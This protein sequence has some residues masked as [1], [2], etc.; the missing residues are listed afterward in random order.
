MYP[1]VSVIFIN[2]IFTKYVHIFK[3]IMFVTIVGSSLPL[4]GILVLY[5]MILYYVF[6]IEI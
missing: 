4:K 3:I 1:A 6:L 5:K 2:L